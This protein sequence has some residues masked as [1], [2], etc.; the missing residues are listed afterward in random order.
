MALAVVVAAVDV[1]ANEHH[2]AMMILQRPE[3]EPVHLLGV[4]S[5]FGA[6]NQM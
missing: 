2:A 1:I 6:R 5:A 4:D 3:I